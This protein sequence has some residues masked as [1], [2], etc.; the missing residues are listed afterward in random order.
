MPI[1]YSKYAGNWLTE[2]R[3]SI[4]KRADN[5]CEFCGIQNYSVTIGVRG[6]EY[7]VILT[8]AHLDHD[9]KNNSPENLKALCQPCH[10]RYDAKEKAERRKRNPNQMELNL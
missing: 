10:L 5:K 1:D 8:V 2:I 9:I 7:K 4:L 6:Q 3:P